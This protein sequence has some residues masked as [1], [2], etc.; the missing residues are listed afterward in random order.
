MNG[1]KAFEPEKEMAS[2]RAI[3]SLGKQSRKAAEFAQNPI[4]K[5]GDR[6][7]DMLCK[8]SNRSKP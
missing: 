8:A 7:I 4:A 2:E 3:A 1:E 6:E 5:T